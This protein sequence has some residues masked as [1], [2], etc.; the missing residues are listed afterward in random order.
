MHWDETC[1]TKTNKC[2]DC[3]KFWPLPGTPVHF[4][5]S[6]TLPGKPEKKKWNGLTIF[7]LFF[8]CFCHFV[9][10]VNALEPLFFRFLLDPGR[11][12][13]WEWATLVFADGPS[14][15]YAQHRSRRCFDLDLPG[16]SA[17]HCCSSCFLFVYGDV[18]F[19]C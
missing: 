14:Q 1:S 13:S 19:Q 9:S 6:C 3:F 5:E 16:I 11:L 2:Q 4:P 18:C 10:L 8:N 17:G 7:I 12:P 15:I